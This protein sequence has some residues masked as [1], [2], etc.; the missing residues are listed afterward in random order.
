MD[1]Q[2]E[3]AED[4]SLNEVEARKAGV[5]PKTFDQLAELHVAGLLA[6]KDWRIYFPHRNDFGNSLLRGWSCPDHPSRRLHAVLY[7]GS[8]FKG[9]ANR[10]CKAGGGPS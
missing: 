8:T 6:E 1:N 7:V 4:T 5:A 9:L 3:E 2:C 10:A